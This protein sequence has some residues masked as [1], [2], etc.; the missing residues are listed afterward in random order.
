MTAATSERP[1]KPKGSN[2]LLGQEFL[3]KLGNPPLFYAIH[4]KPLWSEKSGENQIG[5]F[6]INVY[7]RTGEPGVIARLTMCDSAF[8]KCVDGVMVTEIAKKY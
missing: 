8:V 1:A 3:S 5:Y 4:V 2:K 7:A 6:R